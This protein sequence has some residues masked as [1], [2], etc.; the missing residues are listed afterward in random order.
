MS[1][2]N[3]GSE[4]LGS[5]WRVL[6]L[7]D[8]RNPVRM[9]SVSIAD[10]DSSQLQKQVCGGIVSPTALWQTEQYLFLTPTYKIFEVSLPITSRFFII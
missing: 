3:A 10:D 5:L 7:S 8:W 9:M 1:V 2:C 6:L 4:H